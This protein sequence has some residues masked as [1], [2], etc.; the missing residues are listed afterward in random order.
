MNAAT[1]AI[2]KKQGLDIQKIREAFSMLHKKINGKQ[3]IY[4]DSAATTQKPKVVLDKLYQFYLEEYGKPN[5][6]HALSQK[7]TK[8]LEEARKKWQ[9][10]LVLK[11]KKRSSSAGG[12]P[13]ASIW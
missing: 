7:A 12:A 4:F 8:E 13:K 3:I 6:E 2:S 11:A 9:A 5:E 10:L 1:V